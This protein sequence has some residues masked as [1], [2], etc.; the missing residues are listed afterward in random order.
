MFAIRRIA[1]LVLALA[2]AV[3]AFAPSPSAPTVR[4]AFAPAPRD[5]F[6]S[7]GKKDGEGGGG[8]AGMK[9]MMDQMK[10]A[11]AIQ[12]KT[13]EMQAEMTK[14][15]I[16]GIAADGKVKI[17][18][19]GQQV[20]LRYVSTK[21]QPRP[22]AIRLSQYGIGGRVAWGLARRAVHIAPEED[23]DRS[24]PHPPPP[25]NRRQVRDRRHRVDGRRDALGRGDRGDEGGAREE[26]DDDDRKAPGP[27]R[28]DRPEHGPATV[29]NFCWRERT[30]AERTGV[31]GVMASLF[32]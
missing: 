3:G 5:L 13:Q 18:L 9:G 28:H 14:M 16:E 1:C 27:L 20:P 22:G 2:A 15:E 19:N 29:I 26:R 25:Q 30:N 24:L 23:S 17:V 12:K 7:G 21:N 11:Q 6:G 8:L 4:R 31:V 10:Q 32:V